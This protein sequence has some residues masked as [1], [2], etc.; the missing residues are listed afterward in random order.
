MEGNAQSEVKKPVAMQG[1]SGTDDGFAG[2]GDAALETKAALVAEPRAETAAMAEAEAETGAL[3]LENA[4]M[5]RSL[6]ERAIIS[7]GQL[8]H[9]VVK[10]TELGVIED[11]SQGIALGVE[12]EKSS[13]ALRREV[14]IENYG[15]KNVETGASLVGMASKKEVQ[16]R[17][18]DDLEDAKLET[19]SGWGHDIMTASTERLTWGA[20]AKVDKEIKE[21]APKPGALE[22]TRHLGMVAL[23]KGA[24]G[25]DFGSRN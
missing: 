23:L 22:R 24:F 16:E 1:E 25:R 19:G 9:S 15:R 10:N 3:D 21:K 20:V 11:V 13:E 4:E 18:N 8:A 2:V 12:A 7:S 5:L 17:L 6:G 14:A